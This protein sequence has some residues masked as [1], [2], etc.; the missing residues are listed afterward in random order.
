[1]RGRRAVAHR[2]SDARVSEKHAFE[3]IA[4]LATR[5]VQRHASVG[6][7]LANLRRETRAD[8]AVDDEGE[9]NKQ[10]TFRH[11]ATSRTIDV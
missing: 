8:G 1:M 11:A 9:E 4:E 3:K 2:K 7:M 6:M 10:V 5:R